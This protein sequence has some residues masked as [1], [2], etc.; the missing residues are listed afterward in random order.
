[1][2]DSAGAGKWR[3][4]L[5]VVTELE[6][7]DDGAEA[8]IFGDG[9]LPSTAAFGLFGGGPGSV[10]EIDFTYHDGR[11]HRPHL[12]DLVSGIPRGTIYR[13]VAG[14]GGGY[15]DPHER[16]RED[17]RRDLRNGVISADAARELYGLDD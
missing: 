10:N 15:G 1:M 12:K 13:Q 14:G 5:G 16:P 3:G 11:V 8:S 17:V 4:G 6:F 9:D 2:P 7:L